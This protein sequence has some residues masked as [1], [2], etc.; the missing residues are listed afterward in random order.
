MKILH[1][2]KKPYII[3]IIAIIL[4]IAARN[5]IGN[6]SDNAPKEEK[7]TQVT[8]INISDNSDISEIKTTGLVE[9][10]TSIDIM[11]TTR[12]TV[13][14]VYFKTGDKVTKNKT[15]SVLNDNATLTNLNIAKTNFANMQSNLASTERI[16]DESVRLAE[17]N[18]KSA[19]ESVRAAEIGVE[20]A[21]DNLNN[22]D[23]LTEK[24]SE[25]TKKNAVIFFEGQLN[26]IF[27][28]LDQT[29]YLL[30]VD[31]DSIELAG[32]ENVLG[33]EDISTLTKC[34]MDYRS[35]KEKY[36]ELSILNPDNS[37]IRN[38]MQKLVAA[39]DQT[40]QMI[41][42]MIIVLDNTII[43]ADF[44]ESS[45]SEQKS[46]FTG[47]LNSIVSLQTSADLTLQSLENLTLTKSQEIDALEN[48]L[49]SAENQLDLAKTGYDNAYTALQNAK[50]GKDQ[51]IL[52]SQ[53]SLDNSYGQYNLALAQAGDLNI[54]A[55]ISGTITSK[56]IE[57][58]TEINPGQ[59]IARIQNTDTVKIKINLPSEDIYRIKVDGKAII[60]G[61]LEGTIS[62]IEP[63]ADP[64]TKKVGVEIIFDN[65]NN[66]LITGTFVDILIP[67]E[68]LKKSSESSFFV[69][70]R[71]VTI[72]Q[73]E[74][75]VYI[76]EKTGTSTMAKKQNVQV[77]KTENALIEI[78][79]GLNDDDE[80]IING[81]KI[82]EDGETIEIKEK[83]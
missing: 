40:K 82:V 25:D 37:S 2:L 9:A 60:N 73:T 7:I 10:E 58:G 24:N 27:N 42:S 55:P 28:V 18:L 74:N 47:F 70:L 26:T 4:I 34:K 20:S 8:T 59:M 22:A 78:I 3:A 65:K 32:I 83:Q 49:L 35:A 41:D 17:I 38:D 61:Q 43:S 29:N 14:G 80:L 23:T 31:D 30:Q 16:T 12:G 79:T 19:V 75:I 67:L 33:K 66:D 15:L 68:E 13:R 11:A 77:G 54:K 72:G 52:S 36:N 71:A 5:I 51:Q 21:T 53:T 76:V 6:N 46:I 56:N 45:L 39:L 63:A 57:I 62:L 48:A 69:P 44:S 1:L 64:V 50:E 81:A